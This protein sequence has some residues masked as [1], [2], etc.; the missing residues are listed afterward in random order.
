LIQINGHRLVGRRRQNKWPAHPDVGDKSSITARKFQ[1]FGA[2][3]PHEA[4]HNRGKLNNQLIFESGR[5]S[6]RRKTAF[7]AAAI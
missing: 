2:A 4:G 5:N 6:A 3:V 1:K 7:S